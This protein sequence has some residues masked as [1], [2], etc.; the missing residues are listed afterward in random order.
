MY[1]YIF[2]Y[3]LSTDLFDLFIIKK[4]HSMFSTVLYNIYVI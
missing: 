1:M 3:Y 2:I 4:N